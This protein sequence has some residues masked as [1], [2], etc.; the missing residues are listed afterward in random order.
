VTTTN[1]DPGA[2]RA[3]LDR[4]HRHA[5]IRRYRSLVAR[6]LGGMLTPPRRASLAPLPRVTAGQV[7]VTFAGHATA[8]VRYP[9][10]SIALDPML[11]RWVGMIR[12]A[13]EPGL[14]PGDFEGV[15]LILI[16]HAH[17]D[18]LH[19]PTLERMPRAATIV[20]PAGAAR[21]V[22][23]LGFA[24]VIELHAGG[25]LDVKGVQIH[26]TAMSHGEAPLAQGLCYLVR[27][28]GPSVFLCGDG[29]WFSGF[30]EVGARHAPDIA[31]LPVGGYSPGSFRDRHMS[32]LDAL[33][34]FEDLRARLMIPI[35]HGSFPLSYERLDEP[36]R[37]LAELVGQRGLQDHV[38]ILDP[39][40]SEIFV[41]PRRETAPPPQVKID[42][43]DP[44]GSGSG[45]IVGAPVGEAWA[46]S[47]EIVLDDLIEHA[48]RHTVYA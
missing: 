27:G 30:A 26:T 19:L 43:V 2:R 48:D 28:S 29:A 22:S 6:W 11:G 37:W 21:F 46:R 33:Y 5:E 32:P 45:G 41:A 17:R 31:V 34:A 24:R 23:Q 39:G 38:R 12:R 44:V 15:G 14:A 4:L 7:S 40:E 8:L 16:S 42:P 1:G 20:V 3:E 25:D 18:H 35:H 9:E 10:L 13:V 47:I 36:R